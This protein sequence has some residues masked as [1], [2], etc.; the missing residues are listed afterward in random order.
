MNKRNATPKTPPRNPNSTRKVQH[1]VSDNFQPKRLGLS[2]SPPMIST[3]LPL[4]SS[5]ILRTRHRKVVSSQDAPTKHYGEDPYSLINSG[6]YK[7][8]T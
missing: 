2:I 4:P 3:L 6:I 5:L 1:P 7:R 8:K